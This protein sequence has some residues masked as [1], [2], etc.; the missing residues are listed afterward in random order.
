MVAWISRM[1]LWPPYLRV[2]QD[3][4]SIRWRKLPCQG[5][6]GAAL[7]AAAPVRTLKGELCTDTC[8]H[9]DLLPGR[10]DAGLLEGALHCGQAGVKIQLTQRR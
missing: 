10:A 4:A 3:I 7:G 5:T 9:A 6:A 8:V 1:T 2:V